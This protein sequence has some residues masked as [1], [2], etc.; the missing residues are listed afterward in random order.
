[1]FGRFR[2]LAVASPVQVRLERGRFPVE[3]ARPVVTEAGRERDSP[4]SRV[5]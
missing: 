1:M 4:K 3:G 2:F 5:A